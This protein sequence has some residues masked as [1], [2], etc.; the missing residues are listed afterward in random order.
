MQSCSKEYKLAMK[1]PYRNR[2]FINIF[3]G[4]LNS[5]AQKTI[6]VDEARSSLLYLSNTTK[7]FAG[8]KVEK[9]YA[10]AEDGFALVDGSFYFAPI[11]GQEAY[12]QGLITQELSGAVYLV[13]ST[14]GLDIKGL[15]IDFGHCYPTE[16]T[17]TSDS[18]TVTYQND[19]ER[20][21]TEDVFFGTSF[22]I[23]T[24]LKMVSEN[25]CRLR[26]KEFICGISNIFTNYD[27]QSY[28]FKDFV[29]PIA[30]SLPSQDMTVRIGNTDKYYC[31][32]NP[33]ST[34]NFMEEGME[35]HDFFLYEL[36]DGS[37]ERINGH[38]TYLSN[39][40]SD[41][42]TAQFT[43]K[44]RFCYINGTY[45]K[46]KYR[47][48][49]ITAYDLG[50]DIF[51][52]AGIAE[53]D[54]V[55]DA[56]LKDIVIY[57]PMPPVSYPE[58]MQILANACR[59]VLS[60][61]RNGRIQIMSSF[62]PEMTV[63]ATG[64]TDFS[65]PQNLLSDTAKDV[66][67]M[68]F[69]GFSR[70]DGTDLFLPENASYSKNTG[71]VTDEVSDESGGFSSN[72]QI[73]ID[74][75]SMYTCFGIEIDF[76]SVPPEE[77]VIRTYYEGDILK[78]YTIKDPEEK[79]VLN[80]EFLKFD[81]IVFEFAKTAPRS[82]VAVDQ[83]LFGDVTDYVLEY[84][85]DLTDT[86][87]STRIKRTRNLSVVK[88]IY[89]KSEER[90]SLASD[91][92][93]LSSAENKCLAEFSE[94]S[95]GFFVSVENTGITAQIVE[96]SD[97]YAVLE[98]SGMTEPTVVKY[99]ITGYQYIK[100]E[101]SLNR[102]LNPVGNDRAWENP[103]ISNNGQATDLVEWLGDYYLGEIEYEIKDR[104]DP[105]QDANDLFYLELKEHENAQIRAHQVDVNF[106]GAW[107]GT[108]KARRVE[109]GVWRGKNRKQTG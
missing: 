7:L 52:D 8:Y 30:E 31:A 71:Y 68:A 42:K 29:S 106:N 51:A 65:N 84:N 60:I 47:E 6:S 101:Q 95:Y 16:F 109:K 3:I 102:Q 41:D 14:P 89:S 69:H 43:A 20:W 97:Y 108:K 17:I 1:K 63:T 66:Y 48:K 83:I 21:S 23:I 37:V 49:G 38:T 46:G 55:L 103:L 75:E 32:D 67:A 39:W 13:F 76:H 93:R 9:Q 50:V 70:A 22:F 78:T 94:A 99:E 80:E 19:S 25:E 100:S 81:R 104:G 12:N 44:D 64:A 28:S 107:S 24:P 54:Y 45:R 61:D 92:I 2:A 79:C 53:S 59:C 11:N 34:V 74:M 5:E 87:Q 10:T 91:E 90:I 96:Q 105:R 56:Y 36:D 72:P 33:E 85:L 82:R 4:V 77:F 26:I 35:I 86:P 40:S 57:N 73:A 18:G 58:A 88:T 27:V 62:A 15:T 98:F